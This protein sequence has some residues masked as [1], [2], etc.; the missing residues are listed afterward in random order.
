MAKMGTTDPALKTTGKDWFSIREIKI[1]EAS[2][3]TYDVKVIVDAS[4]EDLPRFPK[5]VIGDEVFG[6]MSAL[7]FDE[8]DNFES[9]EF[10]F[11]VGAD[12]LNTE[13]TLNENASLVVSDALLRVDAKELE[14]SSSVKSLPVVVS[15]SE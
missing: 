1:E 6:G 5:L 14:I 3:T 12:S 9:G 8:M 13:S 4:S 11:T 7:N 10:L 15:E 2:E